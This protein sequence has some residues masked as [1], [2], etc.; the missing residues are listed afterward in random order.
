M[1]A[2]QANKIYSR[3][4]RSE[5][6]YNYRGTT[7]TRA[8]R[9]VDSLPSTKEVNRYFDELMKVIGV[10]GRAKIVSRDMPGQA[11]RMLMEDAEVDR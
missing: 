2:R 6:T 1:R 11:F 9:K 7:W 5:G 3:I 4:N 8:S 10:A